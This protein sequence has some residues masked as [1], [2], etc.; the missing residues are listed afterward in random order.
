V[1][2]TT[3]AAEAGERRHIAK[4]AGIVATGT[5]AS[6]LLGLGRDQTIAAIFPR[7]V[8]DAFFI[9]F[10]IPNVLRQL[11]GEGAVQ[12]AVLPVL[13][14]VR[15]Q[16]GESEARRFFRAV[17]GVS[18]VA[19]VAV[20][21]LGVGF[22]E[23]LVTLF[24]GG[25]ASVAGELERTVLLTR[26]VFPYI[27]CMG[28]AAL[29]AAALNT[30][31]R[32]TATSFAPGLLN[33]SF[34]TLALTLPRL[35]GAGGYDPALALAAGA[36]LGGVL[37]VV[38]Q[39]PS[40]KAIGY[41][42]APRFDFANPGVREVARRMA[43]LLVG[44][45]VYYVDVVIARRFLS[46]LGLGAQS[47]FS[48][49][50]RLCDFPQ[51]IFVMALQAAALPSLAR[52]AARADRDELGRTFAFGMRLALFVAIPAT[53]LFV[54]L[55]EPLVVLL[56][57]R[58]EFDRESAR[59]TAAALVAQ[60]SGVWLVAAV[61]QLLAVYYAVGDTRTPVYVA[62][63]DLIAFI[64]LALAL[65]G[66]L[67][68]VGV[69]WAVSGSSAVQALLLWVL[70]AR[71]VPTIRGQGILGSVSRV[72]GASAV[73]VAFGKAVAR[74]VDRGPDASSV[75]RA[76]P[77]LL[78]AVAFGASFLVVALVLKSPELLTLWTE[79]RKRAARARPGGGAS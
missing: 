51:G 10:T 76:L 14:K 79:L 13:V 52:L 64:V 8:T 22:A 74:L 34:I 63:T 46:E 27:L 62:A 59:Q 15:E 55:A 19:L 12:N 58:G 65:R 44:M 1:N 47:Y 72:L 17:R 20:T 29:G 78:G 3:S 23:P 75:A 43:P 53:A 77:G 31:G 66:P 42:E 39:W 69:G 16:G 24:A 48:W 61:R 38:A 2:P 9:A 54:G 70:L 68:H 32:F 40:L 71:K 50:M 67:G 56:F 7:T 11:L 4:S 45:G 41:F 57:Q 33:V 49:A 26:W 18:L 37:Q 5:L 36:L 6:R 60:G 25:Y 73:A 28:T 30:H 21:A 35:L